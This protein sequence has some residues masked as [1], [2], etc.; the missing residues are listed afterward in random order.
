MIS[1]IICSVNPSSLNLLKLNIEET[2]GIAHEIIAI[3][4]RDANDGLCKVYNRGGAIAI[5][6]V[7]C[8]IHEDIL[9]KTKNWGLSLLKHFNDNK[10]GLI[11][12]A[13]GDTKGIVPSSWSTC[14][15]PTEISVIQLCKTDTIPQ[16]MFM[17]ENNTKPSGKKVTTLDGVFLCT[18][19]KI[20]D[21]FK[22]DEIS[23]KGF[24]GYDIDYSLQVLTKYDILVI[25]DILIYHFSEGK[26]DKE[27]LK[28]TLI[29]TRKWKK[30]LPVS[31]NSLSADDLNFYHWKSLQVFLQH[32]FNLNY[33]YSKIIFYYLRY[34]FTRY[35]KIRRFLS[36]GKYAIKRMYQNGIKSNPGTIQNS[37]VDKIGFTN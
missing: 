13:G 10:V 32:L 27:W 16:D 29:I 9:F 12:L 25:F 34:S 24:H 36:M 22:F 4:N 19:K 3:D 8:F 18:K 1:I 30:T 26:L 14:F 5:F 21:Q 7:L 31:V 2:I 15:N 33:S 6:P 28:S 23:L 20:F 37:K 11:G 35:F 17:P